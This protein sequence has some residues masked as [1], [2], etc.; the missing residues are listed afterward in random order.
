MCSFT[1]LADAGPVPPCGLMSCFALLADAGP[2]SP[3]WLMS[4]FTLRADVLFRPAG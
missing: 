2:V 1:L 3:C 4:C